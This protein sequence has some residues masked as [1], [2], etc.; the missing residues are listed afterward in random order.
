[1]SRDL[2]STV[3]KRLAGLFVRI[4]TRSVIAIASDISC[5]TNIT[6]FFSLLNIL[7]ISSLTSSLV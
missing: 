7:H 3:F 6:V 1:M 4:R 2:I 5:V